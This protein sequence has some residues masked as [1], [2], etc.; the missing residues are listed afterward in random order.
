MDAFLTSLFIC[1]WAEMGDRT[2]ILCAVMAIR[3][4]REKPVILGLIAATVLNSLLSA[5]VGAAVGRYI[6]EEPARL[7][8][9][10]SLLFAGAG[11]IW[12]RRRVDT[13]D[14]W[15]P[16]AFWTSFLGL[17]ILQ[18]GDKGQF[19]I[20]ATSARTQAPEFAAAGGALGTIMACIA[21]VLLREKMAKLIPVKAIR[22]AG[23]I[24]FL[25]AGLAV[26]M[27]AWGLIG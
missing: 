25:L 27:S 23:G 1:L 16:G 10:L 6:S 18:L 17:F 22:I 2:Q 7:F 9:A 5:Y 21:A 3:F 15:T 8:Y 11:M 14:D 20:A 13:L 4:G 24:V 19:I 26:A 12:W